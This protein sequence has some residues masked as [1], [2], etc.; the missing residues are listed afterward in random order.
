MQTDTS[1]KHRPSY[2]CGLAVVMFG[3]CHAAFAAQK[4]IDF[5]RDIRPILSDHCYACHG[6]DENKRKAGLRLDRREDAFKTLKS[7]NR[8]IVPGDVKRSTLVQR[9]T[10]RDP[11]ELM[12]PQEEGKPLNAGQVESLIRW[13]KEGAKW[14]N[15]WSFIPPERPVLPKV[16]EQDWPRDE[17][18]YF[19]LEQLEK[20]GLK[21]A[22]EADKATL[23]RRASFDLTGL[24]PT[25]GEVD[26]FLADDSPEAYEKLVDRL[27]SSVHYGERLAANWLDLARYA[28]TSG[29]HFDGVRFMW[30]WRDWVIDAFNENKPYD[31]F[32]VEQLAGDLLPEP[33][34]EQRIATGF[35]RNNMTTDE[36][37]SDPDEYINKYVVDRVSTLG[38]VWLGMTVGCAE[39]HDHKYDPLLTKEFYKLYAFFHNVPEKGLDRIRTDNPPPRL[40]APTPEQAMQ[41]VEADFRLRDAEKTLQDRDNELGETQ[42]KWERETNDKPPPK[43]SDEGLLALVPFDDTLRPSTNAATAA[44]EI[45]QK[46]KTEPKPP[47]AESESTGGPKFVRDDK[48]QFVDG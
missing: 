1:K 45:D 22:P 43:P 31:T 29:Y 38:T 10:S 46:I 35:V 28:D 39:C 19:I 5:N 2:L 15:H 25:I 20:K 18:D 17:I 42:E 9:L 27:L 21:P 8:A 48:P 11:D 24:P 6:P 47:S 4:D 7:G 13:V 23:I 14:K 33:T 3:C 16:R 36:G 44:T 30:L 34:R 37:G 26:A 40:A 32:T 41:F 12:P